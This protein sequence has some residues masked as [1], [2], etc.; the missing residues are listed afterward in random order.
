IASV[1]NAEQVTIA[2]ENGADQIV[3]RTADHVA[4]LIV[5]ATG[6]RG[7]DLIVDVD[8]KSNLDIDIA[9]LSQGGVISSY[10]TTSS[11]DELSV[12]L[13]KAMMHGC[14]L[15]FVYIY[16]VPDEAKQSAIK[17]VNAC[18]EAGAY[19]PR[20]GMTVPLEQIADAHE[21][22]ESGRIMGKALVY[23]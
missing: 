9:C 19:A 22:L 11:I 7:V 4:D 23:L 2:R 8:V 18:L 20:I 10:A 5:E 15:R 16:R 13:L 21:R 12:P 17:D 14:V 1:T 3:D 6:G